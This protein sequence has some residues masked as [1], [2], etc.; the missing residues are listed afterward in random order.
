MA[1]VE[2][3]PDATARAIK[4]QGCLP[5]LDMLFD[6]ENEAYQFYR[7]YAENT[8]FFVR[9]SRQ[10]TTSKNI[11]TRRT[12]V[13][14]KQGFKEKRKRVREA[15]SPRPETRTGCQACMTIRL[16]PNGRYRVTEFEPNHNHRLE[17]ASRMN[18]L[19]KKKMQRKSCAVRADLVDE[20]MTTPEFETEEEAYEFYNM[21]AGKV[22]FTVRKAKT[23]VGP[24]NVV[25]KRMF[26][27]S[28]QGFPENR[29]GSR[30]VLRPDTRIGCPACMIIKVTPNGKYQVSVFVTRHNHQLAS[31]AS[32]ELVI[33][34]N[35]E[36]NGLDVEPDQGDGSMI[37]QTCTDNSILEKDRREATLFSEGDKRYPQFKRMKAVQ[38]G[39]VGATLEYLQK[40]QEENP[41]FFYAIQVDENDSMTNFFWAD[42]KSVMDFTY[43]GDTVC[44]DTAYRLYDYGRPL[45]LFIG[46]NHH[47]QPIVFGSAFLYE[48]SVKSFMWLFETFKMANCGKQ[49]KTILTDRSVAITEALATVWPGTNHRYCLWQIYQNAT[50]QL[51]LAF[52]GSKTLLHEF[53]RCLFNYEYQ[54]EFTAAWTTILEKYDLNDNQWLAKLFEDREKWALA[55]GRHAFYADMKSVQQKETFNCDLKKDLSPE[56]GLLSFFEHYGRIL[57]RQ[58]HSE[59]QAN[60]YVNP[61]VQKFPSVNILKQAAIAYTHA[62]FEMFE[63]EFD[64]YMDCILF[65][66]GEVGTISEYRVTTEEGV[67]GHFVKFNT[68]DLTATCTCKMFEFVGI[69]CH[70]VL[71]VLDSRN[72]KDLPAEYILRRWRKDARGGFLNANWTASIWGDSQSSMAKRYSYLCGIFSVAAARAAKTKDS[73]TFIESQSALLINQVEK[74]LIQTNESS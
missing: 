6:N 47:K 67:K 35:V 39:D 48:E 36:T 25:T 73:Y 70:H 52:Q 74:I 55:Y 62:A 50:E 27:C 29:K 31:P 24:D 13:C 40:M 61:N 28:R 58:R 21:Y 19:R 42:A 16:T 14:F 54:E 46:M 37:T 68:L 32:A 43:F 56:N 2:A 57:D 20:S 44:L 11:V 45:V 72:L 59:L 49:P 30:R 38:I 51:G 33:S 18:I 22:G 4:K 26:V 41:S 34:E 64:L 60:A 65:S 10:W 7:A 63:K 71:K 8:G 53:S 17:S 66:Y 12:F 23:T 1:D 5:R 3:M 15:L 69:Q 9:K